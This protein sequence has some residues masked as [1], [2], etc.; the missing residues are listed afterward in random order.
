MGVQPPLSPQ[1]QYQVPYLPL[2]FQTPN[3]TGPVQVPSNISVEL[4][5]ADLPQGTKVEA[6]MIW[7]ST[8]GASKIVSQSCVIDKIEKFW[9]ATGHSNLGERMEACSAGRSTV[10]WVRK[11][12]IG[13]PFVC[14]V[15]L[16]SGPPEL[17]TFSYC[18][19]LWDWLIS[20]SLCTNGILLSPYCVNTFCRV[21]NS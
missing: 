2:M 19:W 12:D 5:G 18:A 7:C 13:Q 20:P 21:C 6:D 16:S 4:S 14:Q 8:L 3:L 1:P 9:R 11:P 10:V 17:F 15:Y